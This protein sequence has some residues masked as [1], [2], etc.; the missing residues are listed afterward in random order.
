MNYEIKQLITN[1]NLMEYH[2]VS[3]WNGITPAL[4]LFFDKHLPMPI[5]IEQWDKY[6]DILDEWEE[7]NG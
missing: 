4:V 2:I 5:P 3:G 1:G 7:S 6:W